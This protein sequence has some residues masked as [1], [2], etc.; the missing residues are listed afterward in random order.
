MVIGDRRKYLT[1]ILTVCPERGP[2][3]AEEHGWP[4]S[5]EDMVHDQR[6]ETYVHQEIERTVNGDL[7]RYEQIKKFTLLP[8]D[9]SQEAGEL[10]PTQKT[11]AE[12]H[13]PQT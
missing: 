8:E 2:R 5:P 7:A 6:F 13:H 10:T 11:Q 1:A 9:F 12:R 4:P 3:L